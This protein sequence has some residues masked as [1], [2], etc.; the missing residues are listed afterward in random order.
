MLILSESRR[1]IKKKPKRQRKCETDTDR[2]SK[3]EIEKQ[4][5]SMCVTDRQTEISM[6]VI[7]F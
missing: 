5:R 7:K 1:G 2:K 6:I 4:M 3:A